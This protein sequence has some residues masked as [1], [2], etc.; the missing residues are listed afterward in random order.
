M[1][2]D[3]YMTRVRMRRSVN[4][5]P[6]CERDGAD[7]SAVSCSASQ[8]SSWGLEGYPLAS[9]FAPLQSFKDLYDLDTALE[10]GTIFNQL[11]LPFVC[12][13]SQKGGSCRG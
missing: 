13:N 8:G 10:R 6:A 12:S 3:D 1:Y 9:V 4:G 11:Y 7:R 2:N 5:C